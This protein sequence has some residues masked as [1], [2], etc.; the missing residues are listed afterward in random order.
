M[1]VSPVPKSGASCLVVEA[2]SPISTPA[3]DVSGLR[4]RKGGALNDKIELQQTA[5]EFTRWMILRMLYACRPGVASETIIMRVL[6]NLDFDCELD[7][8]RE[9]IQYMRSAGLAETGQHS[10]NEWRARLTALGVAVVEYNA[11]APSGIGRPRRWR[12]SKR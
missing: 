10:R 11:R 3:P 9:A 1:T 8:V 12:I 6:R 2:E 4:Y 5:R 7:D